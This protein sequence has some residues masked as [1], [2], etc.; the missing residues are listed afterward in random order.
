MDTLAHVPRKRFG[1]HFLHEAHFVARIIAAINPLPGERVVEIGPGLGALTRPLLERLEHLDVVEID[2]DIVA[3]LRAEH[4]AE[5]VS[6]HS[7]DALRFDFAALGRELRI[8]GNLPYNI[9]TPLLFHLSAAAHHIRDM[10]FMLQKEVVERMVAPPGGKDYGKL[11]VMLQVKFA[12]QRLFI[13]PPGAFRPPPKV[14]S[15]IVRLQPLGSAAPAI[16]DESIFAQ[17]VSAAFN[18]RRKMLRQSLKALL[19]AQ[20]LALLN[21]SEQARAEQLRVE[22]FVRCANFLAEKQRA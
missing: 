5:R 14:E 17:V 15:A 13:V 1:Q 10:T 22:D 3:R 12:M 19:S 4:G 6:I 8:V 9:S 2:R 20:E 21:I 11:S 18:Q 7:G 16:S